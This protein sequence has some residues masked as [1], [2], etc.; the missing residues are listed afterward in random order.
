MYDRLDS[1]EGEKVLCRLAEQRHRA[2]KDIQVRVMKDKKGNILI[3]EESV[4]KR[5]KFSEIQR[6]S[7]VVEIV[8]WDI[9]HI[10]KEKVRKA[11]WK[12]KNKR[13]WKGIPFWYFLVFVISFLF[14]FFFL[15][16]PY[17]YG[18]GPYYVPV[19]TWKC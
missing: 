13:K 19:G 12:M 18:I 9:E 8:K 3:S 1:K 17:L 15:Y 11:M 6:R 5:W 7:E 14:L 16:W 10:N 2:G 4:L